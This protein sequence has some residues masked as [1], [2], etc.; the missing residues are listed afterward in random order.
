M[1]ASL[2]HEPIGVHLPDL[3]GCIT[4]WQMRAKPGWKKGPLLKRKPA[5]LKDFSAKA[6]RRCG[7]MWTAYLHIIVQVGQL[8]LFSRVAR[9]LCVP[10]WYRSLIF[11]VNVRSQLC[12]IYWCEVEMLKPLLHWMLQERR[13]NQH[14]AYDTYTFLCKNILKFPFN[15]FFLYLWP[16]SSSQSYLSKDQRRTIK[17]AKLN[18]KRKKNAEVNKFG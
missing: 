8:V 13:L 5:L 7:W 11:K 16:R 14:T 3:E 12:I 10:G 6:N 2:R 18:S 17:R 4:V 9:V 15:L 1:F